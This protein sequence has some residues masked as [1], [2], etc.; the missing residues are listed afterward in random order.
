MATPQL[1]QLTTVDARQVWLHEALAFTP[2]LRDNI[3][4]L[5]KE[6]GLDLEIQGSEVLVGDFAVDLYGT[7]LSTGRT[8]IVENQLESTDHRHLGQLI[9]YAA[10]L[11]AG[12]IVWI[13][14]QFRPE[15]RKALDWLNEHTAKGIDFFGVEI[16]LLKI[17]ES[18]PAPHFRLVAQPNEW[19]KDARRAT[20][21]ISGGE[22]SERGERYRQFFQSLL[23]EARALKPGLTN[24]ST[25][26]YELESSSFPCGL[27]RS[28]FRL[29]DPEGAARIYQHTLSTNSYIS[30]P[31]GRA[32]FRLGWTFTQDKRMRVELYIGTP[33]ARLNE[34]LYQALLARKSEIEAALRF[35]LEW[36]PLES[37]SAKRIAVYRPGSIGDPPERLAELRKW[38]VETM[39]RMADV[40]RPI[41]R[42]LQPLL[43]PDEGTALDEVEGVDSEPADDLSLPS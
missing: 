7:D 35:Q 16:E 9:T 31:I 33:D 38:A 19:A 40:F 26:K 5:G 10:G 12:A 13:T 23:D 3:G 22:P 36:E 2:W 34:G 39:I 15:H 4:L 20:T 30:L 8:L 25:A 18:L 37:R 29:Y 41:V 21:S 6:L 14:P 11:E 43:E 42:G 1:G 32:G 17:D 24:T 28:V 27:D